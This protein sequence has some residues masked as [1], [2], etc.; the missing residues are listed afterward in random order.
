MQHERDVQAMKDR[1]AAA[2]LQGYYAALFER[3]KT[4]QFPAEF[5]ES[6]YAAKEGGKEEHTQEE[7]EHAQGTL[8]LLRRGGLI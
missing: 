6:V 3:Q 7:F 8:E 1:Q 2:I 4:I 5:I